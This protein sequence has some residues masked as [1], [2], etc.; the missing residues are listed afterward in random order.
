MK[1]RIITVLVGGILGLIMLWVTFAPGT[2][3]RAEMQEFVDVTATEHLRLLRGDLRNVQEALISVRERL[4][5]V[6]T[7]LRERN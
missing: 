2:V 6:E 7:I 3:T 1:D 4:S 5:G